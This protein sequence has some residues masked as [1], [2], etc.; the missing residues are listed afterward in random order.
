MVDIIKQDMTDIWA[1]AGDVVA[2]NSAK[3]RGGWGVEAVPRQWWN[4]FENRQ[5]T[6]IAYMLQK[7]VPEWDAFTE[8][9]TN[10]S[11]VQRNNIVYK[12]IL[13]GTNKDP[14]TQPLNW[15]KAFIEPSAY[16][17]L[18]RPLTVTNNSMM[19]VDNA[20]VAQN[21]P[22]TSF[23]R[24]VLNIADSLA[25][26]TLI[27]AQTANSNLTALS[28]V[29]A[30]TNAL[31]YFTGTT[32]MGTTTLTAFA[33]TILDDNDAASV[34]ATLEL[35]TGAVATVTT[36]TTDPVVGRLLRVGDRGLG[37]EAPTATDLNLITVNGWSGITAGT[38]NVPV[39][40]GVG[41]TC[42]TNAY[43]FE[44]AQQIVFNRNT[45]KVWVRRLIPTGWQGWI[46]LWNSSN[47]TKTSSP[48]DTTVGSLLQVGDF[49]I[50]NL[51]FQPT[52][53]NTSID[54]AGSVGTGS[55]R[56]TSSTTGT[57]PSGFSTSCT[58]QFFLRTTQGGL[59]EATQTMQHP[60][61]GRTAI[62]YATG[63]G[64]AAAPAWNAWQEVY[65]TGN[66]TA[67]GQ[68][69]L[70][71]ADAPAARTLIGADNAS[72]L[73]TG[74]I[75]AARV[76]TLN[77]ST[78]GNAATATKLAT[79]RTI[80]GVAF[81]GTANI[82]VADNTKAVR[83][84]NSDITS[85]SGLT[86]ALSV[87]QGGT[88]ATD[89]A[90]ARANL[91]AASTAVFVGATASSAG[92]AGLVP[93]P[94]AGDQLKVLSGAGTYVPL[95]AT[96]NWGGIG[97]TLSNQADLQAA[98][99]SKVSVS[100]QIFTN[101]YQSP[102]QAIV[103]AGSL[104]I[105][106]GLGKVPTLIQRFLVCVTAQAGYVPGDVIDMGPP[107]DRAYSTGLAVVADATKLLGRYGSLGSVFSVLNKGT[108][109]QSD[110]TPANWRLF[111]RAWA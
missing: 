44:N 27:G 70:A 3:V 71:L 105:S 98:L 74:T 51:D 9:L 60:A 22:A 108:G 16:L 79:S 28:G 35:G 88:G 23:G 7:G 19:Y 104:S 30:T 73:T 68:Q 57:F 84:A 6:N 17:E 38:L 86:T 64:T 32:T 46:E 2:P 103:A 91:G 25:G 33:R 63:T 102:N 94:A 37:G 77:Q 4:W 13:T 56:T 47:L 78:T 11:Y 41:A 100:S 49:G 54:N 96:A 14:A 52:W 45:D 82:T 40:A 58:V 5:D 34:R 29:T 109:A 83:G 66:T 111:L 87:V 53:P 85:L 75:P 81:D 24:S 55:Y 26:R 61:T 31:V 107:S 48:T 93:A 99:N 15:V 101:Y 97:G 42:L 59:F 95:V 110:I 10:K 21:T 90:G 89:A 20:G 67:F 1:V 62:R 106:H 8:Y 18:I 39:G 76:P 43:N 65:T 50:G 12:C 80:N 72:N 69:L 92:V 36:S